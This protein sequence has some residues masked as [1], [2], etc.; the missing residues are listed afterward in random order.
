MQ[1]ISSVPE[2]SAVEVYRNGPDEA[3][4]QASGGGKLLDALYFRVSGITD[5]ELWTVTLD[6]AKRMGSQWPEGYPQWQCLDTREA[7]SYP[8]F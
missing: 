4:I 1:I 6:M 8:A 2:A 3:W 5:S 7:P